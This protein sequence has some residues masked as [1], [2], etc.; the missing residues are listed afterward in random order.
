MTNLT[1]VNSSPSTQAPLSLLTDPSFRAQLEA[2]PVAAFATVGIQVEAPE[3]ICL[4]DLSDLEDADSVD[5]DSVIAKWRG[6]FG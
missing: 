6:L 1:N 5:P 2:D 4:P 3:K